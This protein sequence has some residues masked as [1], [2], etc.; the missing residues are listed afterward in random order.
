MHNFGYKTRYENNFKNIPN[1]VFWFWCVFLSLI[2]IAGAIWL[3]IDD[4]VGLGLL[5]TIFGIPV[6]CA[7]AYLASWISAVKI[8][9]KIVVADCLIELSSGN[10]SEQNSTK[11][12]Y[13]LPEL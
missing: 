1:Y 2:A 11:I 13:D 4:Y 5:T 3:F 7:L 12:D 10:A 6:A 8:S 9:Q